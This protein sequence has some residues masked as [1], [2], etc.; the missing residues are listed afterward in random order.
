MR[1]NL[2]FFLFLSTLAISWGC[3]TRVDFQTDTKHEIYKVNP[4]NVSLDEKLSNLVEETRWIDVAIV[5]VH[6]LLS[7]VFNGNNESKYALSYVDSS[8]NTVGSD[9]LLL[10][11]RFD[12]RYN[13]AVNLIDRLA[14]KKE[15]FDVVGQGTSYG[16]P[17]TSSPAAVED[18]ILRL[19]RRVQASI[20]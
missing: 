11:T 4:L 3:T 1:N 13:L 2:A 12:T 17:I 9:V 15:Y 19:Y 10:G 16:G 14:S 8:I 6:R 18:T 5:E 7:R 20:E